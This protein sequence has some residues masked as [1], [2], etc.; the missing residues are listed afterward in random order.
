LSWANLPVPVNLKPISGQF[1]CMLMNDFLSFLDRFV[2]FFIYST[3][4]VLTVMQEGLGSNTGFASD[5]FATLAL[6]KFT[7]LLTYWWGNNS[8]MEFVNSHHISV[9]PVL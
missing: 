3:S 1:S 8:V 4:R 2:H 9:C 6:Y 5:S 7:Y